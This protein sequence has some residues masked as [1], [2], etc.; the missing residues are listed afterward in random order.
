MVSIANAKVAA[1]FELYPQQIQRKLLY[2]R[3]LI[4]D[5]AAETAGVDAVEETLKWGEP[6]Y[7]TK[8][9]STIRIHWKK[10]SPHQY[11]MYFNCNTRLVETFR[12]RFGNQF[13]FEGNRAIVFNEHDEVPVEE[14]QQCISSSLTY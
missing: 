14:L 13:N 5:T 3:R 12:E 10:S 11:A 1:V 9:G 7:L 6:S 4:L 2:L 8:N